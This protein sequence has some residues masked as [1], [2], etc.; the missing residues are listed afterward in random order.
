MT[1]VLTSDKPVVFIVDDEPAITGAL[2]RLCR[3][4]GLAAETFSSAD[5]FLDRPPPFRPGCVVL[6]VQMPG[7]NGLELQDRLAEMEDSLPL[8][9]ISG[10][11][12]IPISV[13]AMKRGAVDFLPKPV[14][15]EELLEAVQQ[16]IRQAEE[17]ERQRREAESLR[18]RVA[19]LTPREQEVFSLVASGLLNKQIGARLGT[20]EKTI[21]AHRGRVMQKLRAASVA[22]LVRMAAAL[23]I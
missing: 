11:S 5:E 12:D 1:P 23:G 22:D 19:S 10:Q 9:F 8:V 21:K 14:R 4:A 2:A 15:D 6:D 20:S 3:S 17:A 7:L 13:R 16:A 18:Q